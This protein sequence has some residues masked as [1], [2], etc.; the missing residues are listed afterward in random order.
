MK[1]TIESDV[2]IPE[3]NNRAKYPFRKMEVGQCVLFELEPDDDANVYGA[4]KAA[5]SMCGKRH[6]MS[7]TSRKVDRGF[8]IWRT[9]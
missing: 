4:A 9:A 3:P 7:F 1:M 5:A 2:P 8:R 6:G